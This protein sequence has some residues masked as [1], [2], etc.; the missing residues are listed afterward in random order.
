MFDLTAMKQSLHK[1]FGTC[2][3]SCWN[4]KP[5]KV[6]QLNWLTPLVRIVLEHFVK[7]SATQYCRHVCYFKKW[8]ILQFGN[9]NHHKCTTVSVEHPPTHPP[10]PRQCLPIT[11]S[12]RWIQKKN[13]S[14]SL[15][16]L[17]YIINT[18]WVANKPTNTYNNINRWPAFSSMTNYDTT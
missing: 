6:K 15:Q 17:Y 16:T 9:W 8:F 11:L 12:L 13:V 10:T 18:I 2:K 5:I 14:F 3:C 1:N 7:K 4:R